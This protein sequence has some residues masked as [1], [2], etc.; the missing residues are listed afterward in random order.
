MHL[1][2]VFALLGFGG[3]VPGVLKMVSRLGGEE[4]DRPTAAFAQSIVAVLCLIYLVLGIRSFIVAR[5]NR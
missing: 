1:A 3:T 4:I 2:L 5:K